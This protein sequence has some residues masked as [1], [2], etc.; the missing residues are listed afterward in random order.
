[1]LKIGTTGTKQPQQIATDELTKSM[2]E[3]S[4]KDDEIKNL[5][6]KNGQIEQENKTLKDKVAKKKNKL[7][8]KLKL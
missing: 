6:E 5:K 8:G 3:V 7:K 2:S 4:L 1:M